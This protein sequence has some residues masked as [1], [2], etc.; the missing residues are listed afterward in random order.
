MKNS[1]I[2]KIVL[3]INT[4]AFGLAACKGKPAGHPHAPYPAGLDSSII[5]LARPVNEQVIA[6]IPAI[7][8][9]SGTR[10]YA[11]EVSGVVTYD[12]RNQTSISSRVGG[13]IE[14]LLI[15]YNYQPV[16]KGQ[17]IMEIYSP[18]LAAAQREL[19]LAAKN[20]DEMLP[21]AKQRLEL[22]GMQPA[23]IGQVLRTGNI[24]YRV[25]IYSNSSGYILEKPGP[26]PAAATISPSSANNGMGGMETGSATGGSGSLSQA[27]PPAAN[28]GIS[29][30]LLLRE[31]Q[32]VGAGQPLFTVYK[33]GSLVAE[34][35]FPSQ[36]A[37][38][39]RQGQP[40][41]FYPVSDRNAMKRG[42]IGLIEPVFRNGRNFTLARV[43]TGENGLR[44]GQLLTANIPIVYHS[45]WWV[46]KKAVWRIGNKSIVYRQENKVYVPLQVETGAETQ[47]MVQVNTDIGGWKI[48]SNA[49]YLVGSESFI[50]PNDQSQKQ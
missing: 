20:G 43:Y 46:P 50:K 5:I 30:P 22:L 23:Q 45:G 34:F 49:S 4:A 26:G 12:T 48:A 33:A 47:E 18:E 16:S 25:P 29:T 40:L 7:S 1:Y 35:A 13:R 9:Q 44:A 27:A 31:G 37:A 2:V 38:N 39:I 21:R 10:I 28:P 11:S 32:Y 41:L 36:L 6:G 24:L 15:R 8:P 3:A 17:L 42:S 14:K 19:L